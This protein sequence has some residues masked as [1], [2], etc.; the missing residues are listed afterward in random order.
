MPCTCTTWLCTQGWAAFSLD[1]KVE[2]PLSIV[3]SRG[4]L[5]R[6]Q[7]LFQHLFFCK[8]VERRLCNTWL[9][10][11][12][13]KELRLGDLFAQWHGLRHR[14]LHFMQN[15]TY[16]MMTE[17]LEPRWHELEQTI[18]KVKDVDAVRVAMRACGG[19]RVGWL[20]EVVVA[21]TAQ[22]R[23]RRLPV[24]MLGPVLADAHTLGAAEGGVTVGWPVPAVLLLLRV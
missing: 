5:S 2:W 14:M 24:Q 12:A 21:W 7:M 23:A 4:A 6:Y 10:Q 13:T 17:V 16:Y 1:Y 15:L 8:H 11:Q 22:V 19:G 9:S 3:L 20:M 18:A